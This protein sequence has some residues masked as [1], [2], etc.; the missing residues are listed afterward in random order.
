MSQPSPTAGL[1]RVVL[2]LPGGFCKPTWE[3]GDLCQP[4]P[5][6]DSP[7]VLEMICPYPD[8]P[9]VFCNALDQQDFIAQRQ[10]DNSRSISPSHTKG[11]QQLPCSYLST[12]A[13]IP[14]SESPLDTLH[15]NKKSKS[16]K[17]K[18]HQLH[19]QSSKQV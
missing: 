4:S 14:F 16:R 8:P 6:S 15:S 3:A 7:T 12:E 18:P 17:Q 19:E 13:D 2:G 10:K 9:P 11:H 1:G 5:Q